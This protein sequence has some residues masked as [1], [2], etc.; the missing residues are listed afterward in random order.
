MWKEK[1]KNIAEK[2]FLSPAADFRLVWSEPDGLT[3]PVVIGAES[4]PRR[5][6]RPDDAGGQR[7]GGQG[8]DGGGGG[9][10]GRRGSVGERSALLGQQGETREPRQPRWCHFR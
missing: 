3:V 8:E 9:A 10:N 2:V 1:K 7:G 5:D 4:P 6:R